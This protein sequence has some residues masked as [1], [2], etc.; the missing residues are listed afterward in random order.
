MATQTKIRWGILSTGNIAHK[1]TEDLVTMDDAEVVAVGSRTQESAQAFARKFNIPR[2]YGSY[3]E[4]ANDSDVDIVYI[5]TPHAMHAANVRLCLNAGKHV[6][7]EKAFTINAQEAQ[8]IIELAREKKRFLMEAVWMRFFPLMHRL[9]DWMREGKLGQIQYM[10]AE[11][12][13]NFEFNPQGRLF[14]PAV[15][16]GALLDLGIYPISLSSMLFGTP[17]EIQTMVVMGETGVDYKNTSLFHFESGVM[18]SLQSCLVANLTQSAHIVGDKG[19]VVVHKQF[20]NPD[21]MTLH[22]DGQDPVTFEEIRWG[23]GYTYE[24]REVMDCIRAGK[25]ESDIMPLDESLSI[26]QTMDS[27]RAKWGLRYPFE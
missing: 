7:N 1:F 21:K 22:L 26:M 5:G 20:W 17:Q 13:L 14:N 25:I 15:G 12:G 4:L 11:F 23:N 9:R 10:Q 6:L 3:E 8:E 18:A 27:L 16:G 19:H 2:A 24:A